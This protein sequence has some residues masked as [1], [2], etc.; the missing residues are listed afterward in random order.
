VEDQPEGTRPEA[1]KPVIAL[2]LGI[3]EEFL[4]RTV[5]IG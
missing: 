2:F 3:S 5:V 4:T 1:G